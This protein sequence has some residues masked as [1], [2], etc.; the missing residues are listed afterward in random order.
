[1]KARGP[2][3]IHVPGWEKGKNDSG[4]LFK[5]SRRA[6]EGTRH[7]EQLR[8]PNRSGP[9]HALVPTGKVRIK[10]GFSKPNA[11]RFFKIFFYEFFDE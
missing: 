5:A 11:E 3:T 4:W 1:M 2:V 10:L 8:F 9:L 7:P 6:R